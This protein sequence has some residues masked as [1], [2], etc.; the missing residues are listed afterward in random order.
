[1]N[2]IEKSVKQQEIFEKINPALK[3]F[4]CGKKALVEA[5]IG[6]LLSLIIYDKSAK[7][8]SRADLF[9]FICEREDV[10]KR[11]FLYKERQFAKLGKASLS[12][13]EAKDVLQMLVDEVEGTNQLVESCKMCLSSEL[14]I[15]ELECLV[16]FNHFVTF[17][18]LNCVEMSTQADL[19]FTLPKL[20]EDLKAKRVDTWSKFIVSIHGMSTPTLSSDLS[21]R[22]V[23]NMCISAATAVK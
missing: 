3:S 8:C 19:L 22:I 13:L 20:H 2:E 7:S 16:Y 21:K 14:F 15:T 17:P 5:G 18:F 23:D 6:A 9:D 1:M 4:F 12:I 11:V 10:S